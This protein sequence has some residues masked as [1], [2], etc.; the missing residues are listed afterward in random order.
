MRLQSV[1]LRDVPPDLLAL[2]SDWNLRVLADIASVGSPGW[3]TFLI[4]DEE[5]RDIGCLIYIESPLY[6]SIHIDTIILRPVKGHSIPRLSEALILG[7][8][9]G[10]KMAVALHLKYLTAGTRAPQ[11]Y[12]RILAADGFTGYVTEVLLREEAAEAH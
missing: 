5:G 8:R 11:A 2:K 4:L 3:H 7:R 6:D 12:K 10:V 9:M 1:S